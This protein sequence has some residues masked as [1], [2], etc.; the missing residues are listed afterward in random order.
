MKLDSCILDSSEL[1]EKK[2]RDFLGDEIVKLPVQ[3]HL[4]NVPF[5]GIFESAG[6]EDVI[7]LGDFR[8][9]EGAIVVSDLVV[10][11]YELDKLDWPPVLDFGA[12][13]LV[14]AG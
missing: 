1:L 12:F 11:A 10:S 4:E 14:E 3:K 6:Q 2:A 8:A 9:Q 7:G 5:D 13:D